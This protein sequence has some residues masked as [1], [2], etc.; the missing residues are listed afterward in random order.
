MPHIRALCFD[1]DNTLWDVWPVIRRAEQRMYDFLAER[2]PRVVALVTLEAMREARERVAERFPQMQ[3]DFTFLRKQALRDHALHC[4]YEESLVEEAF[5][6]FIRARN[7]VE[8]YSD[9]LPGLE[10][11]RRRFRLFTASNGNADLNR[12]GLA[13]F[14]ERTVNARE[15]GALKPAPAMFH[16]AIEGT[17]LAPREVAYIGDDPALD[18]EG[19]RRAGMRAIWVD[20]L[21]S[22][23]PEGIDPPSHRVSTLTELVE[24]LESD[25]TLSSQHPNGAR[26]QSV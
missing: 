24:L 8:L 13:H 26:H 22:V 20:R 21:Q 7:E 2:Y 17:D 5:D 23:W 10:R 11:L 15:V 4:G 18:V 16:R 25:P 3:H 6:E 12:I 14:F 9:V 19:A 1:L